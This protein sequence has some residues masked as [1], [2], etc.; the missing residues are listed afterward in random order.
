MPS[1]TVVVP[2]GIVLPVWGQRFSQVL[3]RTIGPPKLGVNFPQCVGRTIGPPEPGVIRPKWVQS[4]SQA[5][6]IE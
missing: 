4:C 5:S 1:G 2:E 3:G 6:K